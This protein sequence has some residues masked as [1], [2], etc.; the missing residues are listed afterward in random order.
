MANN[1]LEE[2]LNVGAAAGPFGVGD[3]VLEQTLR[4]FIQL[5]S[6]RIAIGTDLV[7]T[8]TVPWL[9][10]KWYTG[11]EGSFTFP[12]DDAAV[13]DPTKVGTSSYTVKLQKGQGRCVS[14]TPHYFVA[15][16]LRT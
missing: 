5:Q 13:V 2:I 9:D 4:D 11:V 8:R 14:L 16:P 6:Y 10:F 3:G 1:S 12:I 15:K 7:G